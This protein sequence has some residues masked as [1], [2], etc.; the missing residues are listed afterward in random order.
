MQTKIIKPGDLEG[1]LFG[2]NAAFACPYCS[3]VFIVSQFLN[4]KGRPCPKCGRS[5]GHVEGKGENRRAYIR[6]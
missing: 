3:K 5:T 2:N 1:D 4:S 6:F